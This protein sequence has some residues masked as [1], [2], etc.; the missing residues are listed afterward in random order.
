MHSYKQ[1]NIIMAVKKSQIQISRHSDK[2]GKE[3]EKGG[4]KEQNS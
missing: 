1:E 2:T 4:K 3:S